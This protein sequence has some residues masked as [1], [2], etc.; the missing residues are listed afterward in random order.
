MIAQSHTG[1]ATALLV[2]RVGFRVLAFMKIYSLVDCGLDPGALL[3]LER[4]ETRHWGLARA[5]AC[6][7]AVAVAIWRVAQS[8]VWAPRD[9]RET[10]TPPRR[11]L[12]GA[13]TADPILTLTTG[14]LLPQ[15]CRCMR[16]F[17]LCIRHTCPGT[18]TPCTRAHVLNIFTKKGQGDALSV[19]VFAAA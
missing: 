11:G 13:E 16:T 14:S 2:S 15:Q 18:R 8:R 1:S 3:A 12:F 5:G 19:R 10:E 9:N 4:R 6:G 7:D 17:E